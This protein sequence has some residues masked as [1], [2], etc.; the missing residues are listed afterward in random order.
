MATGGSLFSLYRAR[1]WGRE[2]QTQLEFI[3]IAGS[4]TV[5][6][7][8]QPTAPYRAMIIHRATFNHVN[9]N[10]VSITFQH[11]EMAQRKAHSSHQIS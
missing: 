6:T 11:Q 1:G 7:E 10:A 3:F 5:V 4:A 2:S 8:V 9:P